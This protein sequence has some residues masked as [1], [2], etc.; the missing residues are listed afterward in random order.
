MLRISL[1]L[2]MRSVQGQR[3]AE[4]RRGD[5]GIRVLSW[6]VTGL[7]RPPQSSSCV[8]LVLEF[9]C[10]AFPSTMPFQKVSLEISGA[11]CVYPSE[12]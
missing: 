11:L 5:R 6:L 8:A 12:A 7:A 1:E 2:H 10:L 4:E 9:T 3:V